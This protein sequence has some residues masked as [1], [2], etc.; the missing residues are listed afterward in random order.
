MNNYD[1]LEVM[2]EEDYGVDPDEYRDYE[3]NV[4]ARYAA[5][6]EP[7]DWED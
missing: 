5:Y 6:L 3:R 1:D 4:Q 2:S 7:T